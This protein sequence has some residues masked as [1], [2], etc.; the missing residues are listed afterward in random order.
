LPFYNVETIWAHEV[1]IFRSWKLLD[2]KTFPAV[3]DVHWKK[4][5]FWVF[6]PV[7]LALIGS[8]VF[9]Y[10]PDKIPVSEVWPAFGV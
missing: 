1:D 7:G 9:W 3:Q 4:L 2:P 8:I 5:P 6:I 10:H